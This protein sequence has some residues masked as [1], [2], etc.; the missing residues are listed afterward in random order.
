MTS[1][2]DNFAIRFTL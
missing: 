1:R 2:T